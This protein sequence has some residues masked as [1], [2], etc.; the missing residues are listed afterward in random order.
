MVVQFVRRHWLAIVTFF[1]IAFTVALGIE[2]TT[3]PS[4]L[5]FIYHFPQHG[6]IVYPFPILTVSISPPGY[7]ET[8]SSWKINVYIQNN[9]YIYKPVPNATIGVTV[10]SA[11]LT[12]SYEL[13]ADNNGEALFQFLPG[14]DSIAFQAYYSGISSEKV[15]LSESYVSV[16]IVDTL[17]TYNAFSALGSL[18]SD[19]VYKPKK[20]AKLAIWINLTKILGI[21]V[22][23]IFS[24]VTLTCIYAKISLGTVWGYPENIIGSYITF[25]LLRYVFYT[26]VVLL[27]VYWIIKLITRG[28]ETKSFQP[29]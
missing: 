2:I 7:P 16:E 1:A 20:C 6:V 26:G 4:R 25:A 24:F 12:K 29:N 10:E 15:V 21:C 19:L 22:F 3:E 17:L 9:T 18:A 8:G 28:I 13:K 27:F 23:G 11:G 14:Y 5:T